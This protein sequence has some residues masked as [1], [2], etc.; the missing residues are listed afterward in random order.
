MDRTP[1]G[2]N[3]NI[4]TLIR[5]LR[6]VILPGAKP[7]PYQMTDYLSAYA[8]WKL[9][10]AETFKELDGAERVYS[11]DFA[12]TDE[13]ICIFREQTCLA[14]GFMRWVNF[15]LP[16]AQE[17]SYFKVWPEE[18]K[19][20]LAAKGPNV[21]VCSNLTVH[22]LARG[23]KL[24]LPYKDVMVGLL[25]ERLLESGAHAMTGTMRVD[26]GMHKTTFQFGAHLLLANLVHHN[27]PVDLV[28]FFPEK[29]VPSTDLI[30][31]KSVER[32]WR[33]FR[34]IQNVPMEI[35]KSA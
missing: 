3:T 23:N 10:W 13:I 33:D 30:V 27:V 4:E 11:D 17:D 9:V 18:A 20:G 14:M 15:N 16:S 19:K 2:A 29:I 1:T 5:D 26:R 8:M 28:A 32:L 7:T 24:G 31:A 34:S 21:I 35:K 6:V 25:V 12:R 22:P